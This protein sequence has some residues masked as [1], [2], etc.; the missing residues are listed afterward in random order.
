MSGAIVK[1]G[2][3]MVRQEQQVL[4]LFTPN[5]P[6]VT[7]FPEGVPNNAESGSNMLGSV[8]I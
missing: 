5:S 6:L 4:A 8:D 7:D 3:R 2:V 1:S